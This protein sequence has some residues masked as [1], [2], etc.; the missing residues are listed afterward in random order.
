MGCLIDDDVMQQI[1]PHPASC[2]DGRAARTRRTEVARLALTAAA[3]CSSVISSAR[4]G[5]G[6]PA[7][8]TRMSRP[9]NLSLVAATS[10]AGTGRI[11]DV[12]DH[13]VHLATCRPGWRWPLR[14]RALLAAGA[15]HHPGP[16]GGQGL[17][18]GPAQPFRRGRDQGDLAG[19]TEVHQAPLD[20]G[21]IV[22]DRVEELEARRR[23]PPRC[24]RCGP[25]T[26]RPGRYPGSTEKAWPGDQR[27]GVAGDDVGIL[28]LLEADAVAGAVDERVAV[29]A[30]G[31]DRPGRPVDRLAGRPR[32]GRRHSGG[33]GPLEQV[34][35]SSAS[36]PGGPVQTVRVM[37]EQ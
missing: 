27:Q 14:C 5:G 23:W 8:A 2:I 7:L 33:L 3:I 6:P 26:A 29:A 1:R 15:D 20:H 24:P 22:A 17:G 19:D 35:Q 37:S 13:G 36:R 12:G 30:R 11:G 9:P 18:A 4:P 21:Q 34:V 10:R 16:L 28:V 32:P 31:D 25:R